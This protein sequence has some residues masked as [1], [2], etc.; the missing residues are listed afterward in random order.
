MAYG[1]VPVVHALLALPSAF[2]VMLFGGLQRGHGGLRYRTRHIVRMK[3]AAVDDMF[4]GT[5]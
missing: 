3:E 1:K 5:A 2:L 4:V